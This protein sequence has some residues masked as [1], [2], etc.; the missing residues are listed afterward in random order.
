MR[1][2]NIAGFEPW[3]RTLWIVFFAQLMT[4]IGFSTIFPFLPLYVQSLGVRSRL[5][6]ELA[7]GLV[8]SAQAF[9][10]M[11]ASPLWGALADRFGR[12]VMI[13]RAA[14]GGAVLVLAMGYADSAETLIILRAIQGGV[15]GSIS[16]ANALIAA[17]VPRE[18]VGFG[19]GLMQVALWGGVAVGPLIGGALADAYGYR[20]SFIITACL[21]VISGIL[22]WRGVKEEFERPTAEKPRRSVLGD[23]GHILSAP[24][25]QP[26]YLMRFLLGLGTVF[27]VPLAP[28][29][30]VTLLPPDAPQN[31]YT[32]MIIA[33]GGA[34]STVTAVSLGR[35]GDRIGHRRILLASAVIATIGYIPQ[36]L[37]TTAWQLMVLQALT[38][39]AAGGLITSLTSLL[40]HFTEPGE[41]G[42][43]Y[44]FD[45]ALVAGSRV[46]APLLGAGIAYWLSL[47]LALSLT[48]V[49]FAGIVYLGA[50]HLPRE[51][52]KG[53][54]ERE[55]GQIPP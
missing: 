35:L 36:G 5:S 6:V 21:L 32:G 12:K 11:I 48:A 14:F 8:F 47:R 24:G 16:A 54:L 39:A 41:E 23:W 15:T 51:R 52:E 46:V 28:L 20:A 18:R 45:A 25:V 29:F 9:T 17:T 22:V 55:K 3:Q 27:L 50:R 10:M 33:A 7:A 31:F 26:L 44:G 30:V 43:V 4:V 53:K 49:L 1:L 2:P 42:S 40:A 19:L 38:G 37:V 13:Q 34:A